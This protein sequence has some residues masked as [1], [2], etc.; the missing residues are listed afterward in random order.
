MGRLAIACI[1]LAACSGT[2][3][4]G[5]G[6]AATLDAPGDVGT[7]AD[8]TDR[9]GRAIDGGA[10]DSSGEASG[11]GSAEAADDASDDGNDATIDVSADA[12]DDG[13]D[14]AALCGIPCPPGTECCTA[15]NAPFYGKCY[16]KACLA[17]CQ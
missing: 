14:A 5:I 13:G 1:L 16:N 9:D 10:K 3:A 6:D 11:D 4:A 17:C 15:P 8:S 2:D 7:S 12:G